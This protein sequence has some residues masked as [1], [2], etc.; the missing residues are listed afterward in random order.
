[1]DMNMMATDAID[2][3]VAR[4]LPVKSKQVLWQMRGLLGRDN[5]C[6][7]PR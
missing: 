2:V 5:L 7:R 3:K 1:M 4:T 6:Q